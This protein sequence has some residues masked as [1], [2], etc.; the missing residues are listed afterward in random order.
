[1]NKNYFS[2][3]L[4]LISLF[5]LSYTIFKSEIYY[6]GEVRKDYN[7]YYFLTLFIFLISFLGLFLEKKI[8]IV[9][10]IFFF[11]IITSFYILEI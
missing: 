1:M 3:I 2:I 7:V 8:K 9:I 4:F 6:D 5:I 10:N 11:N